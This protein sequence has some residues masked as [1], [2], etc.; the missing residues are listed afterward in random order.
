MTMNDERVIYAHYVGNGSYLPGLPACDM[1]R[2]EWD[3]QPEDLREL[4]LE[5]GLYEVGEQ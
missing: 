4:A 2:E 3:I 1:T 5:L